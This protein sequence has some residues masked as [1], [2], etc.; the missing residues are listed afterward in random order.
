MGSVPCAY[1]RGGVAP[2]FAT[3]DTRPSPLFIRQPFAPIY[4]G[5]GASRIWR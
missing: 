5:A 2:P 1:A 4:V 3:K